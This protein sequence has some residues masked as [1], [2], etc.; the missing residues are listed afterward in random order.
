MGDAVGTT[1]KSLHS[2]DSGA[3]VARAS[4]RHLLL[5][6]DGGH[7]AVDHCD[8]LFDPGMS[9]EVDEPTVGVYVSGTWAPTDSALNY[10]SRV[11]L[12][13]CEVS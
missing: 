4:L 2:V 1:E 12:R 10:L 5:S 9:V 3:D 13:P 6:S 8:T 11:Y 7:D